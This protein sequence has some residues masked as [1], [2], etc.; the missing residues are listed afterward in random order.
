MR[1]TKR[2]EQ[3]CESVLKGLNIKSFDK[4][5]VPQQKKANVLILHHANL[6]QVP[7]NHVK[8][9]LETK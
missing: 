5:Q 9:I 8:I 3:C 6:H 2:I 4:L 7:F 1:K